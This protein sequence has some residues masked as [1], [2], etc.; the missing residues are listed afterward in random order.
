MVAMISSAPPRARIPSSPTSALARVAFAGIL[1]ADEMVL[2]DELVLRLYGAGL[3]PIGFGPADVLVV[4]RHPFLDPEDLERARP[5]R[6]IMVVPRRLPAGAEPRHDEE[7]RAI[8]RALP[9]AHVLFLELEALRRMGLDEG[10]R[11]ARVSLA[12]C[13]SV[14]ARIGALPLLP[15]AP[16]DS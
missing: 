12:A 8:R 14:P 6:V 9:D 10:A 3:E 2:V 5:R 16:L 13:W 11:V 15:L 1:L 4:G 7:A